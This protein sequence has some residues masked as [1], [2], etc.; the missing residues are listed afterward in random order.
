MIVPKLMIV[1]AAM[2]HEVWGGWKGTGRGWARL[3][4]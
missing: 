3:W 1:V 2:V 4:Q